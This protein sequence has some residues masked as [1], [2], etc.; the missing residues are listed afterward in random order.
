MI[1]MMMTVTVLPRNCP[2]SYLEVC[3]TE[4]RTEDINVLASCVERSRTFARERSMATLRTRRADTKPTY[5]RITFYAALTTL[6]A[7]GSIIF[8]NR[9]LHCT[10]R[11]NNVGLNGTIT[12][13][14]CGPSVL[15]VYFAAGLEQA[16]RSP[17]SGSEIAQ[18]I[19]E[20]SAGTMANGLTRNIRGFH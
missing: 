12:D 6:P 3:T 10:A 9:G 17:T 16:H 4:D 11:R 18:C 19:G 13:L 5:P 20:D 15:V 7:L 1:M 2:A 8:S 14:F